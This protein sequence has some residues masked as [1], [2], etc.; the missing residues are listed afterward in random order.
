MC[1][2]QHATPTHNH[3]SSYLSSMLKL[4]FSFVLGSVHTLAGWLDMCFHFLPPKLL[5]LL[6]DP[7][8]TIRFLHVANDAMSHDTYD[9]VN[10]VG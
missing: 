6:I 3:L 2:I 5:V 9:P 8:T 10:F 7:I 1:S 4:S